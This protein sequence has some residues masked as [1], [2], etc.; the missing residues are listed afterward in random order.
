MDINV[1]SL[2]KLIEEKTGLSDSYTTSLYIAD[3]FRDD[4]EIRDIIT[5][6][7]IQLMDDN[8]KF[9]RQTNRR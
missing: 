4:D 7:V 6:K 9:E 2:I 8:E 3:A 1:D 5:N